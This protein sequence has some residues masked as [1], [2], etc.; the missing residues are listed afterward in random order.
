MEM[1][2]DTAILDIDIKIAKEKVKRLIREKFEQAFI[3][4]FSMKENNDGK[5]TI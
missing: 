4:A 1:I 2:E 3:K 5:Q